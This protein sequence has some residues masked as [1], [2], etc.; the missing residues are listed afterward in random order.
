MLAC[1]ERLERQVQMEAGWNRDDDRV[2]AR[3]FDG[4]G[5]ARV[6]AGAAMI[7][8]ERVRL[9]AIAAGVAARDLA[10]Q[11]S[12]LPAMDARNKTAAK[13]SDV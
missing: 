6:T 12:E 11:R 1:V 9:G 2:D 10:P 3:V 7:P 13:E 8:A 4:S 5:V